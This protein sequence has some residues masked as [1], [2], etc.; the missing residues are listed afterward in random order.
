MNGHEIDD[1]FRQTPYSMHY[2]V[3][4]LALPKMSTQKSVFGFI[5]NMALDP[6]YPKAILQKHHREAI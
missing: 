4:A 5:K 6:F 1:E 2:N 3:S